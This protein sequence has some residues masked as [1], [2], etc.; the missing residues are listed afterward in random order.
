MHDVIIMTFRVESIKTQS[1]GRQNNA[2]TGMRNYEFILSGLK[3]HFLR[4]CW[5][6]DEPVTGCSCVANSEVGHVHTWYI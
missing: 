1:T 6:R 4:K 3:M 2:H 5:E